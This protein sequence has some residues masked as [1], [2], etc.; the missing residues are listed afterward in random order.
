MLGN[1]TSHCFGGFVDP[2]R[3]GWLNLLRFCQSGVCVGGSET[4]TSDG[5]SRIGGGWDIS[6]NGCRKRGC[7]WLSV[8]DGVVLRFAG[9]AELVVERGLLDLSDYT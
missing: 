8:G 5:W 6:L 9:Q 1:S 2:V 3:Q 7:L 4:V